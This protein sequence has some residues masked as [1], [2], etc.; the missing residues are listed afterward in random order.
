MPNRSEIDAAV[1]QTGDPIGTLAS[2]GID[3]RGTQ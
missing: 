3:P 1:R 2:R